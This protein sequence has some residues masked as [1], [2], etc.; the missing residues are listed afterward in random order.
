MDYAK[1]TIKPTSPFITSL[2]SDTIFGHFA[3]GYRYCFG[4]NRLKELLYDFKEKPF[5]NH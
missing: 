3:W 4:E 1:I 5:I 2:Q